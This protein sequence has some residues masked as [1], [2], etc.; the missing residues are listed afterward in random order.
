MIAIIRV[1]MDP[2]INR[3]RSFLK[4]FFIEFSVQ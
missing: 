3:Y 4:G 2:T 1:L